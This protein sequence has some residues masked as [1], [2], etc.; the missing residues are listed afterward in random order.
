MP[1]I[2]PEGMIQFL[3]T[4]EVWLTGMNRTGYEAAMGE[5][6]V[7]LR[8]GSEGIICS[9]CTRREIW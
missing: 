3:N 5:L 8:E 4:P 9:I 7:V 6:D 1:G 2:G